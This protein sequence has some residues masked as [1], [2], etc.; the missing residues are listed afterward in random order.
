MTSIVVEEGNTKYDSRN[1]CNAII[2]TSSNS[3]LLGCNNTRIPNSVRIIGNGAFAG[4][5]C[6]TIAMIPQS[7]TKIE[8]FAFQGCSGLTDIYCY[9]ET[10]PTTSS[11]AFRG[12]PIGDVTLHVPAASIEI[13]K[14]TYPWSGFKDIV[15]LTDNDPNPAGITTLKIHNLDDGNVYDLNGRRLLAPQRGTNIIRM[16]NGTTKKVVVR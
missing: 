7:V 16:H 15:A 1:N 9:A 3:L 10:V 12:T 8:N 2:E 5:S 11:S 6:L 4:C 13:Y 14:A